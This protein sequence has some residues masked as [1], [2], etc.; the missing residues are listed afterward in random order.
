MTA[1]MGAWLNAGTFSNNQIWSFY[2]VNNYVNHC[3]PG[4]VSIYIVVSKLFNMRL[5][6]SWVPVVVLLVFAAF[7]LLFD[8][9]LGYNYMFFRESSGTPF[10]IF[11]NWAN[12]S[13]FIYDVLVLLS[14]ILFICFYY[15]LFELVLFFIRKAKRQ[16]SPDEIRSFS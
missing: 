7:A 4:F 9:A 12:G 16:E 10:F 2:A 14:M 13:L 3:V 1:V 15:A 11:E 5:K 6:D 8:R